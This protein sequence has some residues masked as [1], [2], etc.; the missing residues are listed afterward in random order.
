MESRIYDEQI[1][2]ESQSRVSRLYY[3][4]GTFHGSHIHTYSEGDARK[5]FHS[6]WNGESIIHLCDN[7]GKV[8]QKLEVYLSQF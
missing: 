2:E 5:I 3:V 1:W 4:T 7:H 6:Y 8:Y